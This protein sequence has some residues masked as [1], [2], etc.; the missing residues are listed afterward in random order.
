MHI[1]ILLFIVLAIMTAA[2]LWF[3]WVNTKRLIAFYIVYISTAS[4]TI[5]AAIMEV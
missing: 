3:D 2:L 1:T 4:L 5:V